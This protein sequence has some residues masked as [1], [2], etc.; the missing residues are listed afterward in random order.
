M[1][2]IKYFSKDLKARTEISEFVFLLIKL[3]YLSNKIEIVE[4]K[5]NFLTIHTFVNTM[6]IF[7]SQ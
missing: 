4:N 3:Y 2:L 5:I 1:E 7:L 6:A